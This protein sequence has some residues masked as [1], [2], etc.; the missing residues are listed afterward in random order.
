MTSHPRVLRGLAVGAVVVALALG[1]SVSTAYA[2]I[3]DIPDPVLTSTTNPST[4]QNAGDTADTWWRMGWGTARVPVFVLTLP[5]V[6]APEFVYGNLY[7][8]DRSPATIVNAATPDLYYRSA[9]PDGV[10]LVQ[11]I[12]LDSMLLYPP[13][14]GLPLEPGAT[15]AIE[16]R[17]YY[18]YRF[19]SNLQYSLTQINVPFGIDVTPPGA[20]TGLMARPAAGVAGDPNVWYGSART[21]L[22][23]DP[24][25]YDALSGDGYYQVLIDDSAV[26]PEISAGPTQGRVYS[27]PGLPTPSSITIE[28]VPAGR[29]KISVVVVDRATNQGAA[30]STYFNSDPD[31]PSIALTTPDVC[32]TSVNL[33]C[34][35]TD[36][37][38]VAF[39]DWFVDGVYVGRG[40][41]SPF[42]IVADMT[43]FSIGAHTIMGRATD[44]MGRTASASKAIVRTSAV[45]SSGTSAPSGG[46]PWVTSLRDS[47]DPFYPI[48]R[49]GYRDNSTIRFRVAKKAFVY[50]IIRDSSGKMVNVLYA[51]WR[52]RG[53]NTIKWNGNRWDGGP[54]VDT[55]TYQVVADDG[56]G[57][58]ASATGR[59]S[60]RAFIVRRLSRGRI[61]LIYH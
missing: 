50:V 28:N 6:S 38:G 7:A 51:G 25:T 14:A 17:W 18:H 54:Q 36:G 1:A 42:N 24:G 3:S 45:G 59:T 32:G 11:S 52:R 4:I 23:W 40:S 61:R 37:G 48:R 56:Y 21:H 13:L 8:V 33:T 27:L 20:V 22:T 35:A 60:V 58:V 9:R 49:D 19:F 30:S 41:T 46:I 15:E 47:P 10:N 39:V 55:Y 44:M 12:P 5:S 34:N 57:N 29:H 26:I 31:V 43:G 2:A 16:G 53:S